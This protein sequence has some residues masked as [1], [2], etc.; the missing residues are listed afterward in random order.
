MTERKELS[1]K[2]AIFT[3][4]QSLEKLTVTGS[5]NAR[6]LYCT[7]SDLDTIIKAIDSHGINKSGGGNNDSTAN[8]D[9]TV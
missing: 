7:C 4:R 2:E 8:A 1:L 3:I 5:E 6:I 9:S